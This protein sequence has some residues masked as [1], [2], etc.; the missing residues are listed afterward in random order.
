MDDPPL[1]HPY[2][3][4][5]LDAFGR[6]FNR[7]AEIN[8]GSRQLPTK[9]ANAPVS[10]PFLWDTPHHDFVQWNGIVANFG[11]GG[12]KPLGRNAS[13]VL[14]VF[15]T[16]KD[17]KTDPWLAS[18][19]LGFG[20]YSSS[21]RKWNQVAMERKISKLWS[22]KWDQVVNPGDEDKPPVPV[23]PVLDEK[24]VLDGKAVYDKYQC[25]ACHQSII[26]DDSDRR[27]IA[28]FADVD[29]IGTDDTMAK[30][31]IKYCG[32]DD[33]SC[34]TKGKTEPVPAKEAL[35]AMT[36]EVLMNGA[37][38]DI[39]LFFEAWWSNP[40]G[41]WFP[42]TTVDGERHI[43]FEV[44]DLEDFYVYKGRPLNGIWA[45]AP[46]LHNGSVPNLYELFLPSSCDEGRIP[47]QTCRSKVFSV[48]SRELDVEKVGFKQ[49][50]LAKFPQT[51]FDT[52]LP[53]NSNKG[54][55]FVT[56]GT[57]II[58]TKKVGDGDYIEYALDR[59]EDK[60]QYVEGLKPITEEE[61]WALVEYLKSL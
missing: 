16:N 9:P 41:S 25:E 35:T 45:T 59:L 38:W 32:P 4:G 24:K 49:L 30:N 26:R 37:I 36:T 17:K 52:S 8:A 27:V 3:Y 60:I 55:E 43:D 44:G 33:D 57:P 53:G 54:H 22:P 6:I 21:V 20:K 15:A 2:G 42:F 31:A 12:L 51:K 10:Y 61:R 1:E 7:V 50:D 47:G 34:P 56:L 23:L 29:K 40:L 11:L 39:P 28:Q 46:Y 13:E 5:R 58:K 14:G 19:L 48:G 18:K